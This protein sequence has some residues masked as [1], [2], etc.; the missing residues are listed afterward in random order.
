[1]LVHVLGCIT[2]GGK[3]GCGGD[4]T[5]RSESGVLSRRVVAQRF[6]QGDGRSFGNGQSDTTVAPAIASGGQ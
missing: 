2:S 3:V 1:M 4:P 5:F 6:A